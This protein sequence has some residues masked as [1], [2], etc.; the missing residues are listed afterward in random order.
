[1]LL[2]D[3]HRIVGAKILKEHVNRVKVKYFDPVKGEVI[4]WI[5]KSEVLKIYRY[6]S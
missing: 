1:M 4:M 5:D 3:F 2:C 6:A